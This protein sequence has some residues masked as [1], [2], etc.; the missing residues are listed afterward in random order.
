MNKYEKATPQIYNLPINNHPNKIQTHRKQ[1]SV[2][3]PKKPTG[4]N[5]QL[6]VK[7][8]QRWRN[9]RVPFVLFIINRK[10]NSKQQYSGTISLKITLTS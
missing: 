4:C 2:I 3:N 1:Q 5:F 8:I 9:H 7:Q 10:A 6:I